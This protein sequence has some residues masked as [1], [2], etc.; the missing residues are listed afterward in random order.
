MTRELDIYSGL[1][2]ANSTNTA[3]MTHGNVHA[4][5]HYKPIVQELVHLIHQNKWV[6]EFK[7]AV[8]TAIETDIEALEGIRSLDDYLHHINNF[9]TW[10]PEENESGKRVYDEIC[11]FYFI[12]D[13]I[14]VIRYQ[15]AVVPSSIDL[16]V[17]SHWIV[18]YANA[19][20][21]FYTTPES[22]SPETVATFYASPK[23]K[24][25][26]YVVPHGGWKN[27][28][29]FFCRHIKSGLR[30][31]EAPG[32]NTVVVSPAD[33]VFDGQ[34]PVD[35]SNNVF[36]VKGLPWNI[37]EL[38]KGSK[39]ADHFKGG[40]FMHAFLN[41]TDYH[42]Q[43]APVSGIVREAEIIRGAAYLEVVVDPPSESTG[44]T[45]SGSQSK[46]KKARLVMRRGLRRH[47]HKH[48]KSSGSA[49]HAKELDAPD[50]P[51]Y[52]FIQ[53]RGLVVI[54]TEDIGWVAVL[55]IGMAQVS[56]VKLS[57]KVTE[58]AKAGG[59]IN[60]GDEISHFEFGGSD[61]VMVFG[62]TTHVEFVT[63][64][65]QHNNTGTMIAK[66]NLKSKHV[67]EKI[68]NH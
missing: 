42:R 66:A 59:K 19:L 15:N 57:H 51:G 29:E 28:N 36:F 12:L 27:F 24:M 62:G 25:K 58:A 4:H 41:T 9:L 20:G 61:I 44:S 26:D 13:Q 6:D 40:T 30:E 47:G 32:Y 52:Q 23:Y 54:E 64:I 22:I 68:S 18:K 35:N 38:L 39:Y 1:A 60:K 33:S 50:H 49:N 37:S 43:H 14:S 16:T 53:S 48:A 8:G 45:G 63:P 17:L 31:P 21:D 5:P 56:S 55:P 3:R 67:K 11:L 46:P 34:W 65:G 10:L 2:A 7:L